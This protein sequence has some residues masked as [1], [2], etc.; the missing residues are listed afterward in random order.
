MFLHWIMKR[1]PSL[2]LVTGNDSYVSL[3][4]HYAATVSFVIKNFIVNRQPY[5]FGSF[6]L[7]FLS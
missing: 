1:N 6:R 4:I 3:M 5:A 7:S 2:T